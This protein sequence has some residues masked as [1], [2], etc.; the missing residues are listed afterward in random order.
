[1]NIEKKTTITLSED[2]VKS[3]VATYLEGEGYDIMPADVNLSV[4][5]KWVGDDYMEHQVA[6]FREC[7]AIVKG[8]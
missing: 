7:T 3:I 4:G 2:E 8:E 1:M 6:Y 5:F